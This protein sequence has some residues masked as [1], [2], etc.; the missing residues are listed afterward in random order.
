MGGAPRAPVLHD[1]VDGLQTPR[2]QGVIPAISHQ[3]FRPGYHSLIY[4]S[5]DSD[6][7]SVNQKT[8]A[9]EGVASDMSIPQWT[10]HPAIGEDMSDPDMIALDVAARG[11]A[12]QATLIP[13][14]IPRTTRRLGTVATVFD[15]SS[16]GIASD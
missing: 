4:G 6:L 13:P 2:P 9:H 16:P 15:W 10:D 7:H 12:T 11:K 8:T 5:M 1:R 14:A 3:D